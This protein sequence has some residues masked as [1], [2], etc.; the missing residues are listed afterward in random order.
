MCCRY[1]YLWSVYLSETVVVICSYVLQM[2]NVTQS[3][4]NIL[5]KTVNICALENPR[6]WSL[7]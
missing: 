5:R 2:S 1:S 4:D 3:R 7:S 6:D